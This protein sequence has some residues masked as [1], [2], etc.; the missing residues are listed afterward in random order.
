MFDPDQWELQSV[1][2]CS[3]LYALVPKGAGRTFLQRFA[4]KGRT[5]RR[6]CAFSKRCEESTGTESDAVLQSV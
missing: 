5:G 6:R 2:S 4:E 3:C 1:P